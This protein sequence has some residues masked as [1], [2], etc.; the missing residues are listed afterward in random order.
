MMR[1]YCSVTLTP[2]LHSHSVLPDHWSSVSILWHLLLRKGSNLNEVLPDSN[3]QLIIGLFM[4]ADI[5]C[6]SLSAFYIKKTMHCMSNGGITFSVYK[7][8]VAKAGSLN[9]SIA[10]PLHNWS[11]LVSDKKLT[12][13]KK[14]AHWKINILMLKKLWLLGYF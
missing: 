10:W 4:E 9:P 1:K 5:C 3:W 6:R 2:S 8:T 14:R 12:R 11:R 13:N 7:Y